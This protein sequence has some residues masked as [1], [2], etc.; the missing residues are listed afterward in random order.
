[1]SD[2]G[3]GDCGT[4]GAATGPRGRVDVL[5]LYHHNETGADDLRESWNG[6][7]GTL[8][9]RTCDL[10]DPAQ[11]DAL[12]TNLGSTYCP[13]AL[14]HLA[15]PPL[16]VQPIYRVEWEAYE[17]HLAGTLGGLV[18]PA[19]PLLKRMGRRRQGRLVSV[20][21]AAVFGPPPRGFVSYTVAKYAL[22]G[23]MRCV[24]AEYAGRGVTANTVSPGPMDTA[25][26]SSLPALLTD[27]MR[28]AVP[29]EQ[30]IN[31]A[32]VAGAV[33]W[34]VAEAGPEL[35]GCNLPVTSGMAF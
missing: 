9:L 17:R 34:L 14:V 27:Q 13:T 19:R 31:P 8:E 3:H 2:G 12:I 24:A 29:G 32:S 21:S 1:M 4:C 6:A 23:Y 16:K 26:L 35:T 7:A 10:T 28:A 15:V 20:L 33:W 18:A 5:G 25:L 30:W 22:A 11:A